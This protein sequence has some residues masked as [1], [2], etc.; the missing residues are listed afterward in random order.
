MLRVDMKPIYK[1]GEEINNCI[2]VTEVNTH[3][4]HCRNDIVNTTK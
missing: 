4:T 2:E 3:L 1:K